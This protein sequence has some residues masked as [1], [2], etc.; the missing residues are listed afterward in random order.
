MTVYHF[1]RE[2]FPILHC[3]SLMFHPLNA[4]IHTGLVLLGFANVQRG[5]SRKV[6]LSS[7]SV[8]YF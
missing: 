1:F 5:S 6:M 7:F 4:Y 8:V 2:G 3:L